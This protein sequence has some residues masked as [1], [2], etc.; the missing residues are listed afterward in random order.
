[1]SAPAFPAT[2]ALDRE[3]L[4]P[5]IFRSFRTAAWLGWQIE[6]NWVTD[7]FLFLV[8]AVAKPVAGAAILVTMYAVITG[9]NFEAPIFAYLYLGNAFYMY[10]GSVMTGVSWA[11]IDDRERYKM[12]KYV[13]I[14]PI[15][16]PFYLF[17]RGVARFVFGTL[18]VSITLLAG[19]T[20]LNLPLD[21][22][23][24]NWPMFF[25]A[26]VLGVVML[27]MMGLL[28]ASITLLIANHVWF[29]GD[30]VAGALYIFSGA[31][32]PLEVL[33]SWLRPVGYVMPLTYWLEL[34]RRSLIGSVAE[35]FPAL[36]R[37]SDGQLFLILIGLTL[38]FGLLAVVAFRWCD[39][40][41]RER[42]MIDM[43]TNY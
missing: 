6:T 10:V 9:G 22:A 5:K 36:A 18:S 34:I 42:G 35:A 19:V 15:S 11:V 16:Y 23:M 38:A 20:I 25:A 31:I 13:Y 4:L 3:R 39:H 12:L 32:F 14:A 26:L 24:V 2:R 33:P 41:A 43:V 17:G 40:Q 37:F 21:L 8:Y 29:L 28:L 1:M 27:A 7:P 30:T